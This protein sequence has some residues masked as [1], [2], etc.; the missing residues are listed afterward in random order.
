MKKY[1]AILLTALLL[2]CLISCS[3]KE[4]AEL[5]KDNIP[6]D[7][8]EAVVETTDENVQQEVP[9]EKPDPNKTEFSLTTGLPCT[10][11]EKLVRP[12]AVMYNN[13]EVSL[14]QNEISKADIVYECDAEGGITRLMAIFSDWKNLGEIGSVRSSRDYF[15]SLSESHSAIYVHAGGS[16]SAYE[17][18]INTDVDYVDGVNMNYL[19][20]NTF[21]RNKDRIKNNGYEHSM[22][23]DGA[24]LSVA[25]NQLGYKTEN[26]IY[27][28]APYSFNTEFIAL[29]GEK[30]ERVTLE[31][32]SYITV[33]FEY[34]SQTNTYLKYSYGE[35]H[36]DGANEEQLSFTNVFVLFVK[37]R[38][39]D[40]QG[41][42]DVDLTSGGSG[43]YFSGGE[44]IEITWSRSSDNSPFVITSKGEEVK[45]NPGKTHISLFNR[46]YK[47]NVI[48]E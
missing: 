10:P 45:L 17:K 26:D 37:E 34:D 30:G 28:D 32:S 29:N 40:E 20:K 35:P 39:L 27:Y 25:I 19:P 4:E 24:K 44:C 48:I 5:P 3:D 13:I 41:R 7:V 9:E 23:T 21:Y 6:N 42:L 43:Y 46:N 31:H 22:M 8:E 15:V 38:V 33:N 16:P 2:C 11:E 14:P 47:E 1:L 18:L 36:I 12:I